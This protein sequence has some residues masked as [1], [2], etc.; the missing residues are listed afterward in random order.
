MIVPI[1]EILTEGSL[2]KI[3]KHQADNH[4]LRLAAA[5]LNFK[6]NKFQYFTNPFVEGPMDHLSASVKRDLT[7]LLV[8]IF[9]TG[10]KIESIEDLEKKVKAL[11]HTPYER[12]LQVVIAELKNQK[13]MEQAIRDEHFIQWLINPLVPGPISSF[14]RGQEMKKQLKNLGK[15]K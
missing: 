11:G 5:R 13:D 4:G 6:E 15:S 12:N 8:K 14:R 3:F 1:K 9:G 7:N 10:E 2:G